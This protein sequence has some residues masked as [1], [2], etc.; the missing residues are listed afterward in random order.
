MEVVISEAEED[1]WEVEIA[2]DVE[3]DASVDVRDAVD[4]DNVEDD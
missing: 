2:P 3:E 1:R 4:V